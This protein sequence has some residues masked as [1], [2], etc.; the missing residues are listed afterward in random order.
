MICKQKIKTEVS[1]KKFKDELVKS[2]DVIPGN[3]MIVL[4]TYENGEKTIL[5][6][7]ILDVVE[8]RRSSFLLRRLTKKTELHEGSLISKKSLFYRVK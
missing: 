6:P 3:Y 5:A 8:T 7:P 2:K 4:R 1:E